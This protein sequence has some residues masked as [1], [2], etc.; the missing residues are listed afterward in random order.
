MFCINFPFNVPFLFNRLTWGVRTFNFFWSFD[1]F[2]LRLMALSL[3]YC[4][5]YLINILMLSVG[6]LFSAYQG[7]RWDWWLIAVWAILGLARSAVVCRSE[8]GC[9]L[10]SSLLLGSHCHAQG[11]ISA[12]HCKTF[13]QNLHTGLVTQWL[14]VQIPCGTA[15]VSVLNTNYSVETEAPA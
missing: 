14:L 11:L 4:P 8:A 6:L 3:L 13:E 7:C 2:P 10:Y 9:T 5:S 15:A 12:Q 1:S